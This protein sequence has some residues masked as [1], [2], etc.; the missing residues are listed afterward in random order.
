MR[1]KNEDSFVKICIICR[2]V[3]VFVLGIICIVLLA[4]CC[5][6]INDN[7]NNANQNFENYY[8]VVEKELDAF[9]KTSDALFANNNVKQFFININD[10]YDIYDLILANDNVTIFKNKFLSGRYNIILTNLENDL[11]VSGHG[12]TGLSKIREE[13]LLDDATINAI[14]NNHKDKNF[15]FYNEEKETLSLAFRHQYVEQDY[16]VY[17]FITADTNVLLPHKN[18]G[19]ADKCNRYADLPDDNS[20]VKFEKKYMRESEIVPGLTYEYSANYNNL[21]LL[22]FYFV[23]ILLCITVIIYSKKLSQKILN[24]IYRPLI[25]ATQMVALDDSSQEFDNWDKS[26][27]KLISNI[28]L[29]RSEL[30]E[31]KIFRKK[32][33]L[34]NLLYG[35][36]GFRKEDLDIYD[37]KYLN[38]EN[39]IIII[40]FTSEDNHMGIYDE[41]FE[42]NLEREISMDISGELIAVNE[43]RYA[44]ITNLCDEDELRKNLFCVLRF[45]TSRKMDAVIAVGDRNK[46][47][48]SIKSS[49]RKTLD[50]IERKSNFSSKFIVFSRELVNEHNSFYYPI[51][52]EVQF[53]EHILAG[54]HEI[55]DKILNDI[56]L[57]NLYEVFLSVEKLR[58]FKI[59]MMGTIDRVLNRMNKKASD[60]FGENISAYFEI[61]DD[62]NKEEFIKRVRMVFETICLYNKNNNESKR[63]KIAKDVMDYIET[64]FGDSNLSLEGI[65]KVFFI[66]QNHIIRVLKKEIG[67]SYKEYVDD[68]RI[69]E[70]KRLLKKTNLTILDVANK[71]GYTEI[72]S[73]NRLFKKHTNQT[74]NEYRKMVQNT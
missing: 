58:E 15:Y 64:N 63:D 35:I 59:V 71:V 11:C 12:H 57:Y 65:A 70:A 28:K 67:K 37:L 17:C 18:F 36:D 3:L 29:M 48:E 21:L 20:F 53:I 13:L 45:A 39:R 4:A 14:M 62:I 51:D 26:A 33:Y 74:P 30:K 5:K 60:I 2:A 23:C 24:A 7:K 10:D 43:G 46:G 54:N 73:F 42:S 34:R 27:Q 8:N 1:I 52:L 66:S 49:F 40:D 32:T 38:E 61:E 68:V 16:Y 55:V 6:I 44:Y 47:I 9:Q 69:N 72:R 25:K 31:N 22:V 41:E 50:C 19:I 56:L